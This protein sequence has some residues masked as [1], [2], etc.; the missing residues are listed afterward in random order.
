MAYQHKRSNVLDKVPLPG[1]LKIGEVAVNTA[2]GVMYAGVGVNPPAQLGL[3]LK[4]DDTKEGNLTL[5]GNLI[6]DTGYKILTTGASDLEISSSAKIKV[7]EII[8]YNTQEYVKIAGVRATKDIIV[9]QTKKLLTDTIDDNGSGSVEFV[10]PVVISSG[11][12]TVTTGGSTILGKIIEAQTHIKAD[13]IIPRTGSTQ[14]VFGDN[15]SLAAG[16]NLTLSPTGTLKLNILDANSGNLITTNANMLM[17]GTITT[18][19]TYDITAGRNLVANNLVKTNSISALTGTDTTV[20]NTLRIT[21]DEHVSLKLFVTKILPYSGGST[22]N[23]GESGNPFDFKV[24]GNTVLA[25]N[26]TVQ[27]ATTT[28][29]T[30]DL[31]VQGNITSNAG[32]IT[33]G[34][35]THTLRTNHVSARAGDAINDSSTPVVF[36]SPLTSNWKIATVSGKDIQAGNDLIAINSV[37]TNLIVPR[38]GGT[39]ALT[40]T[41]FSV[42]G[43]TG[44]NGNVAINNSNLTITG[45]INANLGSV[46]IKTAVNPDPNTYY[47]KTDNMIPYTTTGANR[48]LLT[49]NFQTSGNTTVGGALTV[50]GIISSTSEMLIDRLKFTG[51]GVDESSIRINRNLKLWNGVT[52]PSYA[53]AIS[54]NYGT[55]GQGVT[56]SGSNILVGDLASHTTWLGS[57]SAPAFGTPSAGSVISPKVYSDIVY[58]KALKTNL[59]GAPVLIDDN[60]NVRGRLY[61]GAKYGTDPIAGQSLNGA[62]GATA[63]LDLV[64]SKGNTFI[65]RGGSAADTENTTRIIHYTGYEDNS[66]PNQYQSGNR[67]I[68]NYRDGVAGIITGETDV[69]GSAG[70]LQLGDSGVGY[71]YF[72]SDNII[73]GSNPGGRSQIMLGRASNSTIAEESYYGRLSSKGGSIAIRGGLFNDV[74][75]SDALKTTSTIA[76]VSIA[77][78]ASTTPGTANVALKVGQDN[79]TKGTPINPSSHWE[80][81]ITMYQSRTDASK[82]IR[83]SVTPAKSTVAN[84]QLITKDYLEIVPNLT[85]DSIN[86]LVSSNSIRVYPDPSTVSFSGISSNELITK[87]YLTL[88]KISYSESGS[89]T[90]TIGPAAGTLLVSSPN[91]ILSNSADRMNV[92]VGKAGVGLAVDDYYNR[93]TSKGA[94]LSLRSG[95]YNDPSDDSSKTTFNGSAVHILAN[96]STVW[97]NGFGSIRA[98]GI[99]STTYTPAVISDLPDP[100]ADYSNDKDQEIKS[101]SNELN[102]GTSQTTFSKPVRLTLPQSVAVN[103]VTG[104]EFITRNYLDI[105][106]DTTDSWLNSTKR[107]RYTSAQSYPTLDP[108]ELITAGYLNSAGILSSGDTGFS[109]YDVDEVLSGKRIRYNFDQTSTVSLRE[110][111]SKKYL[112][113]G[114]DV[115]ANAGFTA[116][117]KPIRMNSIPVPGNVAGN[118]LISKSFLDSYV[119]SLFASTSD[120]LFYGVLNSS[121]SYT[122]RGGWIRLGDLQIVWGKSD[123][124]QPEWLTYSVI[125]LYFGPTGGLQPAYNPP[126]FAVPPAI[127]AIGTSDTGG[128]QD[129]MVLQTSN[130]SGTYFAVKGEREG[131]SGDTLM[132][133]MTFIAIGKGA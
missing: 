133:G 16:K 86:Y 120:K 13:L 95:N 65:M 58:S 28:L 41:N 98:G 105:V 11:G 109:S 3:K 6:I 100:V 88:S 18:A 1:D 46:I 101:W 83:M 17:N 25:G 127:I 90:L 99:R 20:N 96:G 85:G 66:N 70:R 102:V 121:S 43:L 45:Q 79:I 26:L 10:T 93:I 31:I 77:A 38:S 114:L 112:S 67:T 50:S 57:G 5:K 60:L 59:V 19:A 27:G 51:S 76:P 117:A 106:P 107:I 94:Q 23:I 55:G 71:V 116:A 21:G 89:G 8:S 75:D 48:I 9:D 12:L 30:G 82:P 115:E 64:T 92:L 111:I 124:Y 34:S 104:N 122:F 37:K 84:N 69:E 2:N 32:D 110:V 36:D 131:G 53:T 129:Q 80:N 81:E 73:M 63:V 103:A 24:W 15:V 61:I 40:A 62:A 118:E 123:D 74:N 39:V 44:L 68:L 113:L 29:S 72:P 87:N 49:G 22:V 128:T 52:A 7:N 35:G 33:V 54:T 42:T 4:G 91:I 14:T 108:K 125:E 126:A 119:N 97:E 56:N 47:L 132:T 130:D 78:N